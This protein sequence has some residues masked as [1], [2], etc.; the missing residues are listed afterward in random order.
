VL[1]TV[2]VVPMLQLLMVLRRCASCDGL[3]T[4]PLIQQS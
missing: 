3:I 1:L 2:V 4:Y